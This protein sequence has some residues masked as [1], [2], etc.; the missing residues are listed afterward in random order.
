MRA[1]TLL[2]AALLAAASAPAARGASP[3][4]GDVDDLLAA[5]AASA[6]SPSSAGI[7]PAATARR[8]RSPCGAGAGACVVGHCCSQR[9]TCGLSPWACGSTCQP[10]YS[11]RGSPCVGGAVVEPPPRAGLRVADPLAAC[12]AYL[13][14]CPP[15][16]CCTRLGHCAPDGSGLCAPGS[17]CQPALSPASAACAV[18]A[19]APPPVVR[20]HRLVAARA[21]VAPDGFERGAVA[22]NGRTPGPTIVVD[23]GDRV[24]AEFVNAL[25]APSSLHWHGVRHVSTVAQ[26]GAAPVTQRPVAAADAVSAA[27]GPPV[28]V[29]SF[30]APDPG[31]FWWHAHA[32]MQYVDGLR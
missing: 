4:R 17:G 28:F 12:G 6:A 7:D 2:L 29:Y 11:G 21:T 31:T 26:D 9:G 19:T 10:E 22:V 25:P 5:L 8:V 1:T 32:G 27:T 18:N 23:A 15:A 30:V 3:P 16:H 13:A 14:T 20:R 24:V